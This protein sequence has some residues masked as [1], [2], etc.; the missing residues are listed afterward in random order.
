MT[1]PISQEE[2]RVHRF[3]TPQYRA[4]EMCDVRRGEPITTARTDRVCFVAL[5]STASGVRLS[6][7]PALYPP[8]MSLLTELS[9]PAACAE[10]CVSC[11]KL[12][13][14]RRKDAP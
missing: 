6:L 5:H 11:H 10:R 2:E 14:P 3:S 7:A 12:H 9:A 4:P 1:A 8:Y 13:A